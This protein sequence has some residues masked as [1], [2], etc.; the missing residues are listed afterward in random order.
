MIMVRV[1]GVRDAH[2]ITVQRGT[3]Q[4][5]ITLA[6][7]APVDRLHA[8]EFLRWTLGTSWVS[9]E[10]CPDQRD[11]FYVYRSPDGLFVNREYV[12]RGF[13]E[14]TLPS[15]VPAPQTPVVYLGEVDPGRRRM[16]EAAPQGGAKT[17]RAKSSAPPRPRPRRGGR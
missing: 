3:Q 10:V 9:I 7:V 8:K 4:A 11:A 14:A 16:A 12:M 6:G 15:I 17:P 5:D 13:A 2:T 1:I